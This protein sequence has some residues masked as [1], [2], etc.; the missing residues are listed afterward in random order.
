M[1]GNLDNFSHNNH[2]SPE[3]KKVVPENVESQEEFVPKWKHVQEDLNYMFQI[4][5]KKEEDISSK[6]VKKV[7][8]Q[9]ALNSLRENSPFTFDYFFE[10]QLLTKDDIKAEDREELAVHARAIIEGMK[11]SPRRTRTEL[12]FVDA[13]ILREKDIAEIKETAEI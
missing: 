5:I 1:L 12:L 2:P 11:H 8:Y 13:G 9:K 3:G 7:M 6:A 4:P 10:E